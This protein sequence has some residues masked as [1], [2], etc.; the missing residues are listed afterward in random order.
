[1]R[2]RVEAIAKV[3]MWTDVEANSRDEAIRKALARSGIQPIEDFAG[4]KASQNWWKALS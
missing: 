4:A 2:F 3:K 1:M